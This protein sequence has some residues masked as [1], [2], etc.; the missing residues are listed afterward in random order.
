MVELC[1]ILGANLIWAL[2]LLSPDM[3]GRDSEPN[4]YVAQ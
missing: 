3:V 4:K 2:F 1:F